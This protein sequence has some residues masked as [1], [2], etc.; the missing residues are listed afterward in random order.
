MSTVLPCALNQPFLN[1]EYIYQAMSKAGHILLIV[2]DT[3]VSVWP[4]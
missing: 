2:L 4:H 3:T 1:N